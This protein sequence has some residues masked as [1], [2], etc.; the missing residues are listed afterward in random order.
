MGGGVSRNIM[1]RINWS[2]VYTIY[3]ASI[4]KKNSN[5]HIKE[6]RPSAYETSKES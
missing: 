4:E 5:N 6:K 3:N 2:K 1:C